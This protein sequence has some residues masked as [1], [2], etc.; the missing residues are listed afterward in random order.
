MILAGDIGG[1][2]T[3]LALF[4][5]GLKK[6][7]EVF[8][9]SKEIHDLVPVIE[10]FLEEQKKKVTSVSLGIAGPI[11]NGR[12]HVTNLPLIIDSAEL[13]R[14]LK[15]Q[16]VMLINDLEANAWG[17][18]V[19]QPN[20]FYVL[21]KGNPKQTG[22]AALLAAGTGLGEAGLYWDGKEHL[23]FACE[24]GHT[25]F[26]PRN[27]LEIELLLYLKKMYPTHVSYERIVSGPGLKNIYQFLIDSRH[28]TESKEV[29]Q[30][31]ERRPPPVVI[32]EWGCQKRDRACTHAVDWFLSIYGAEAGNAALKFFALGGVYIGGGI[33]PHLLE[34]FKEGGFFK[35]FVEK[36][37]FQELLETIPIRI[38]LKDDTALLGAAEYARRHLPIAAG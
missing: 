18:R 2:K 6:V 4:E 11:K 35:A 25:D 27:A 23:P 30:E 14:V 37:R 1:T 7:A 29:K 12:C 26:A 15:V 31:M 19:L 20:D 21:N 32:S 34:K 24:G 13:K 17:L 16:A 3:H 36:G 33:A 28:E 8:H 10:Q 9:A 5:K 38:V 22:N